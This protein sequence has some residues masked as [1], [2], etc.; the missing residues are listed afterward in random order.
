MRPDFLYTHETRPRSLPIFIFQNEQMLRSLPEDR[1]DFQR[2]DNR[3]NIALRLYVIDRLARNA[4]LVRKLLLS[5][6]AF[7]P[8]RLN[9][10][11]HA[12]IVSGTIEN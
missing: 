9:R 11:F 7:G 3:G 8:L 4:N 1:R 12:S 6:T 2:D 5:H 10:V